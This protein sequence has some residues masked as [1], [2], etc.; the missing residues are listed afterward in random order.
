M[1]LNKRMSP[2]QLLKTA[3]KTHG[4]IYIT[5]DFS[6]GDSARE[7]DGAF[8]FVLRSLEPK[9]EDDILQYFGG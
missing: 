5:C 1:K 9:G 2:Y 3:K 7:L 4:K 6:A 8:S